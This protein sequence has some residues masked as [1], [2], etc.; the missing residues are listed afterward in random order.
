M[1]SGR[2]EAGFTLYELLLILAI[3]MIICSMAVPNFVT[4]MNNARIAKAVGDINAIEQDIDEYQA[5]QPDN[6]LP[7]SLAQIGCDT[8]IDPWGNPYQYLNHAD[9]HGNG[10]DRKDRFL[11]PLNSDYDLYSMGADG[12]S[13]GPIT[14]Q[15]S[16][17]DIIRAEDGSY[18]GLAANF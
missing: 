18:V 3:I 4:A 13:V 15:K 17:D 11:V 16:Q 6:S 12:Q 5:M 14:A 9:G 10:Q 7:D 2:T 1:S 8:M